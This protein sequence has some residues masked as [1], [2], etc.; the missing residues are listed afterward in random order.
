[1]LAQDQVN[2]QVVHRLIGLSA[3]SSSGNKS[4]GCR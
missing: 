3:L 2:P 4:A 1:M